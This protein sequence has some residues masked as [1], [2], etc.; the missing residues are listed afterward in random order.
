MWVFT[1]YGFFS[2]VGARNPDGGI[3]QEAVVIRARS[4]Q[5]M[6]NLQVR[7]PDL[8]A[9]EI[10][11]TPD[12]DYPYRQILAKDNWA[13]ILRELA[14][15]MEWVNFRSDVAAYQGADGQHYLDAIRDVWDRMA[16]M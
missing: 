9:G 16:H 1:R 15:E 8:A 14:L 7:F 12:G 6:Q 2:S 3:E 13:A 4:Q 5:H 10:I 11:S